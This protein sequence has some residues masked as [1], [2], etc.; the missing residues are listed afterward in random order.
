M[1]GYPNLGSTVHILH[2]LQSIYLCFQILSLHICIIPLFCLYIPCMF[3]HLF[4]VTDRNLIFFFLSLYTFYLV[5]VHAVFHN[6]FSTCFMSFQYMYLSFL[7]HH[8]PI[9]FLYVAFLRI[10]FSILQLFHFISLSDL[11]FLLNSVTHLLHLCTEYF[12]C[13]SFIILHDIY[14]FC[15]WSSSH[16]SP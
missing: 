8:I 6:R 15:T 1:S 16:F 2:T 5:S 3:L 11:I 12:S 13:C 4:Y 10:T 9:L 14:H 7:H